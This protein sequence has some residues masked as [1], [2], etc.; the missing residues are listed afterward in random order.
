MLPTEE[1]MKEFSKKV[2]AE[3]KEEIK[4]AITEEKGKKPGKI[5]KVKKIR[6]IIKLKKSGIIKKS[7]NF[8]KRLKKKK[9]LARVL[10]RFWEKLFIFFKHNFYKLIYQTNS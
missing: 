3:K 4:E 6:K 1:E 5:V 10:R 2:P 7:K 8:G 9:S